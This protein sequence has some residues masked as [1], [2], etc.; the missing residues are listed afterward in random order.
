MMYM[1]ETDG[2]MGYKWEHHFGRLSMIPEWPA[3]EANGTP[4]YKGWRLYGKPYRY[5][6]SEDRD[7]LGPGDP[8]KPLDD[9]SRR[10]EREDRKHGFP[11]LD[12]SD[13]LLDGL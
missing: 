8:C 12:A 13:R 11:Q 1:Y 9:P 6:N 3:N 7:P 4:G 2:D 10:L 5:V